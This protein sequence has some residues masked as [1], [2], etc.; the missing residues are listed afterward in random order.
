MIELAALVLGLVSWVLLLYCIF[1]H[2][3][4]DRLKIFKFQ[5]LSWALCSVALYIPSLS[6]QL[7]FAR[8][9]YDGIID[10]VSTFH[11][12]SLSLLAVTLVLSVISLCLSKKAK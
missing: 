7:E 12:A 10:C 2:K 11:L 3:H 4:L 5:A 6:Q 8:D 9:D 1:R